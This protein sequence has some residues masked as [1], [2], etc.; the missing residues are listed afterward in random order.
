MSLHFPELIIESIIRESLATLRRDTS[1]LNHLLSVFTEDYISKKYGQ[2]EIEKLKKI[3]QTRDIAVV[4]ALAEVAARENSI[5][6]QLASENE[7]TNLAAIDDFVDDEEVP[8]DTTEDIASQI[9]VSNVTITSYDEISGIAY[10]DDADDLTDAYAFMMYEDSNGVEFEILGLVKDTGNKQLFFAPYSEID[11][12]GDGMI[13]SVFDYK[14]FESRGVRTQVTITIGIHTKNAL[15]T[16]Y[17][18]QL[19]KFF[20]VSHK[21]ELIER[22]FINATF[23]GSDFS[24]NT[25]YMADHVFTRFLTITGQVEDEWRSDQVIPIESAEIV[26]QVAK[27]VATTEDLGR[28]DATI[29]VNDNSD[30]DD[31]DGNGIPDDEEM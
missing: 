19:V 8:F 18:Y 15:L 28:T 24:R 22:N 11:Y 7:A 2:E 23:S 25:Q 10:I 5:S 3:I 30:Q 14:Q 1:T 29:Q 16:K 9:K 4:H 31:L 6:I 20:I 12:S 21:K 17:I 26:V 27:D 13:K